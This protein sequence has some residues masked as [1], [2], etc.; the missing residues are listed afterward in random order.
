MRSGDF[1]IRKTGKGTVEISRYMGSDDTVTVPVEI[2]GSKVVQI[3]PLFLKKS[4]K[5]RHIIL[6]PSVEAVNPEAFL[7]WRSVESIEASGRR[8][9]SVDSVLYD[10]NVR[11]LL[12]YPPAR[13]GDELVLPSSVTTV[14]EHAFDAGTGLRRIYL[15]S[16]FS[17]FLPSPEKL[18]E[19]E[20]LVG[21]SGMKN[22]TISDGVLYRSG[23]LLF[24]PAGK[25]NTSFRIP[26]GIQEIISPLSGNLC[27]LSVPR[28]VR[29]GVG[30]V[31]SGLERVDVDAANSHYISLDGVLFSENKV[32]LSCPSKRKGELY[33]IPAGTTSIADGAF[34]NADVNVV[35]MPSSVTTIGSEVFAGS[36][37]TSVVM[38]SSLV[39]I[40][41]M[42]FYGAEHIEEIYTERGSISD[43]YLQAGPLKGKIK[44]IH[45]I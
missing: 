29:A 30:K 23:R 31:V 2:E 4:N 25:R 14:D 36:S 16:G 10:G 20:E 44:Y 7:T 33:L 15:P 45:Y 1:E 26:E 12:F 13:I 43:I 11:T 17:S 38:S 19:L 24:Y 40:D 35:V 37:V 27:T 18:P 21:E 9:K 22:V 34:R 32:L 39:N 41:M 42:A 6:P 8:L 28:T 5:V 3:G